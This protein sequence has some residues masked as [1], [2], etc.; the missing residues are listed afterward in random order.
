MMPAHG[1]EESI[2]DFRIEIDGLSGQVFADGTSNPRESTVCPG[3]AQPYSD[4]HVLDLDF[5]GITP[6]T[7]D[8]VTRWVHVP[9]RIAAGATVVGGGVYGDGAAWGEFTIAVPA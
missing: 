5:T 2:G 9:A 7:T 1:I 8:G 3:A 6:T 4:Q